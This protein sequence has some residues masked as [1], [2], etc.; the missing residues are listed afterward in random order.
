MRNQIQLILYSVSSSF[1][2]LCVQGV[3]S[4]PKQQSGMSR[5]RANQRCL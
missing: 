1:V 3:G 5:C 4:W 2:R